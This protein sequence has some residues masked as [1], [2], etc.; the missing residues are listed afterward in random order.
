MHRVGIIPFDIED[1]AI[2]LLSVTSQTR[3]RW[4]MPKGLIKEGESHTE[5]CERE[6]F[7]EAGVKGI[8]FS[9]FPMTVTVGKRTPQG[10][11]QVPVTY[12]PMLVTEQ[13]DEW[14]EKDKRERHWALIQDAVKVA[15]RDDYLKLIRQL[16][17]L[18]PWITKLAAE[19]KQEPPVKRMQAL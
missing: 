18:A 5:A 10:L 7:E 17:R 19:C 11:E 13:L 14:P 8:V 3:G 2:A 1:S 16:E 9:D 6:A 15:Y 12:Y 4:I